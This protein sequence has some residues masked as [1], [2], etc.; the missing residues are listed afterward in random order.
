MD[1]TEPVIYRLEE[2]LQVYGPAVAARVVLTFNG[3]F[4]PYRVW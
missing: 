2:A 3:K 1:R 4:L